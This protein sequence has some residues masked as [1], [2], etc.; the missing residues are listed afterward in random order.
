MCG[1]QWKTCQCPVWDEQWLLERAATRAGRLNRQNVG[2]PNVQNG[3][4]AQKGGGGNANAAPEFVAGQNRA[5]RIEQQLQYLANRHEREH[6]HQVLEYRDADDEW[7]TVC[8]DCGDEMEYFI[9]HCQNCDTD[10]CRCVRTISED[11]DGSEESFD[12]R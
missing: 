5:R 4:G 1:A 11:Y 7:E 9:L 12:V 8:E 10:L 2:A 3:Q 6:P